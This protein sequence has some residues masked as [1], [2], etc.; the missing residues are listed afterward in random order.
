MGEQTTKNSRS[1]C[2]FLTAPTHSLGVGRRAEIISGGA[3][4]LWLHIPS[5][6]CVRQQPCI[7]RDGKSAGNWA[8][9]RLCSAER[10]S[11]ESDRKSVV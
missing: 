3:G 7:Q 8:E 2:N 10:L 11:A 5:P 6:A 1:S 4:G 9:L